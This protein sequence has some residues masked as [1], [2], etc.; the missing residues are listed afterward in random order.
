[1]CAGSGSFWA[2][3]SA[4]EKLSHDGSRAGCGPVIGGGGGER[5]GSNDERVESADGSLEDGELART[6]AAGGAVVSTVEVREISLPREIPAFVRTWWRIY[7]GDPHW[8]PPL[9]SE[10]K[11][12]LDPTRNPYF[13]LADVR[14]FIAHRDGEA[15][16]TIAATVDHNYQKH[17]PGMAFFGFF[18]FVDDLEVARSLFETAARWLRDE[19]GMDRAMGPFNF[20]SNHEFGLMVDGFDSDPVV[21]NPH[22]A[23]YYEPIYQRLGLVRNMDWYAYWLNLTEGVP[24]RIARLSAR[25]LERHPEVRLRMLDMKNFWRD[26]EQLHGIYDDAWEQ[27]WAHVAMSPAEFRFVAGELKSVLEPR[28]CWIVEVE[29]EMAAMSISVPDVNPLVKKMNGRILPFG[30]L[31]MLG[32]GR[33]VEVLRMFALGVRQ[34][35]QNMPLGVCIY[36]RTWQEA[37]AMGLRGSEASLILE[38][39]HRMRGVL[40]KMGGRIHKTYRTF[41]KSL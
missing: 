27:N 2:P 9:V 30:W 19:K 41:E 29:G 31:H 28:L 34:K 1:M 23:S 5:G 14:C 37:L 3:A 12:F 6:R 22:N 15:V 38:D 8:V 39:N 4:R 26:V 36:V 21:L 11:R 35:Y 16:G 13:E 20:T 18:E 33:K 10:R 40:E 17:D 32:R 25:F 7:R 24:E